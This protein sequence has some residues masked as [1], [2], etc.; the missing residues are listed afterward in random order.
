MA[1]NPPPKILQKVLGFRAIK[2]EDGGL[3]IWGIPMTFN[4]LSIEVLMQKLMSDGCNPSKIMEILYN[5]GRAQAYHATKTLCERYGYSK[6]ISDMKKLLEFDTGQMDLIGR[7]RFEW[8]R[9]D[10]ENCTF[11]VRG[12]VPF[13]VQYRKI[14]GMQKKPVDHF[15]RG[16]GAGAVE[17]LTKR[18]VLC[19]E[20]QCLACGKEEC[21]FVIKPVEAWDKKDPLVKSQSV[22]NISGILDIKL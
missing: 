1:F 14:Y 7:G 18:K 10:F 3:S 16:I 17:Y 8:T 19:I 15:M 5:L 12:K 6:T 21:L 20:M 11:H 9:M 2:Y 13:A 4:I 22:K